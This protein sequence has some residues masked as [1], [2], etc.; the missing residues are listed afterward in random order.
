MGQIGRDAKAFLSRLEGKRDLSK[1]RLEGQ[2]DISKVDR[3]DT[4]T[5][6]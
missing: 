4:E 3:R 2:R 6:R 1:G 5:G